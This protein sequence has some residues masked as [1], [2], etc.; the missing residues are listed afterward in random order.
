M[1]VPVAIVLGMQV[2]VV[3][4]VDVVTVRD[5]LVAATRT[6]H[7][8]VVRVCDALV[9]VA[10]VPVIAV[11]AM[12]VA[13]VHEVDVVAVLHHHV[14]AIGAVHMRVSRC[15]GVLAHDSIIPAVTIDGGTIPAA[16]SHPSPASSG[17]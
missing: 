4:V 7:M 15:R 9:G 3:Q 8:L 5:G 10:H 6:M 14:A 2:A 1:L 13:V 17:M 11:L 12:S 16:M